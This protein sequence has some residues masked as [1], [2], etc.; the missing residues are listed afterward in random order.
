MTMFTFWYRWQLGRADRPVWWTWRR[1]LHMTQE[2]VRF[3]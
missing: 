3:R 1:M 2:E